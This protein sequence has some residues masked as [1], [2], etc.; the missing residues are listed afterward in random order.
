MF[1]LVGLGLVLVKIKLKQKNLGQKSEEKKSKN[2]DFFVSILF[3]NLAQNQIIWVK[4]FE[5]IKMNF[6]HFQEM[7]KQRKF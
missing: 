7:L 4:I 6:A 5:F 2:Q 1:W 3:I